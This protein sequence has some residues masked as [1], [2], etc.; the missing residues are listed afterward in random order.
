MTSRLSYT[1][2]AESDGEFAGDS[3]LSPRRSGTL[4]QDSSGRLVRVASDPSIAR[5]DGTINGTMKSEHGDYSLPPPYT[6]QQQ[7]ETS[8]RRSNGGDSKYGFQNNKQTGGGVDESPGYSA[9]MCNGDQR[10]LSIDKYNTDHSPD[11]RSQSQPAKTKTGALPVLPPKIDRL[12]KPSK[13]SAAERLFGRDERGEEDSPVSE[14]SPVSPAPGGFHSMPPTVTENNKKN[15][16][17]SNSSSNFDSYNKHSA[18]AAESGY[19]A[20][21]RS[22][23]QPATNGGYSGPNSGKYR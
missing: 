15:T 22:M 11:K 8:K 13:K 12:K 23:S 20:Y 1:S 7:P 3:E 21:S 16:F 10:Q 2:A 9:G 19:S 4:K 18:A 17:D 5:Q 14:E 6:S